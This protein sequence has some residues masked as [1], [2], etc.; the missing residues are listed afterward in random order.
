MTTEN[1]EDN[2][3]VS[4]WFRFGNPVKVFDVRRTKPNS[5]ESCHDPSLAFAWRLWEDEKND[6]AE[7]FIDILLDDGTVLTSGNGDFAWP[8]SDDDWEYEMNEARQTGRIL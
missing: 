6:D 7:R 2:Y 8:S 3:T 5:F 1:K 4:K